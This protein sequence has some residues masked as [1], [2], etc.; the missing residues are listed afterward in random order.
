L[1][2]IR[3]NTI[4]DAAGTGPID[5]YKQSAAK[6]F[7]SVYYLSGVPTSN[8]SLNLS[9]LSDNGTGNFGTNYTNAFVS[10]DKCSSGIA[11][12]NTRIIGKRTAAQTTSYDEYRVY[13]IT[14]APVVDDQNGNFMVVGDLA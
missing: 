8:V 3:A 13:E 12:M 9:S 1:S 7:A 5:L 6:A 10:A 2:D 4:S 14:S 11:Q